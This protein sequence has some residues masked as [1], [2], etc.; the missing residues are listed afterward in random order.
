MR[1]NSTDLRAEWS[2]RGAD[3]WHPFSSTPPIMQHSVFR[4]S[5]NYAHS[6]VTYDVTN[7]NQLKFSTTDRNVYIAKY[8]VF[9][10]TQ[11]SDTILSNSGLNIID[12]TDCNYVKISPQT[13]STTPINLTQFE[14]S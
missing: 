13:N 12:L 11:L 4:D 14:W 2:V 6:D 9:N 5:Y 7:Y 1:Y 10:G 3:S 8:D